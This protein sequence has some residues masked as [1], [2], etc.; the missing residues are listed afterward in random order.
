MDEI[1][2]NPI[3]TM[4]KTHKTTLIR[5][6]LTLAGVA[7]GIIISKALSQEADV[8]VVVEGDLILETPDSTD[9]S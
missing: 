9:I 4:V 2:S 3:I 8:D 1:K 5:V 7:A 6:G